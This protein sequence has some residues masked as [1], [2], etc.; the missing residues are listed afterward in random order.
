MSINERIG[1]YVHTFYLLIW[2]ITGSVSTD[3][4]IFWHCQI[5]PFQAMFWSLRVIF[6]S[7][8]DPVWTSLI[9]FDPIWSN[10]IKSNPIWPYV[11]LLNISA[12]NSFI[13]Q[14]ITV[15]FH[16]VILQII[17]SFHFLCTI[18]QRAPSHRYFFS[19][20]NNL[21]DTFE[22]MV[23]QCFSGNDRILY[24]L[25]WLGYILCYGYQV[26]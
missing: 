6:F 23:D 8:I 5:K 15:Q 7:S 9:Q 12:R 20:S 2:Y 22:K 1:L 3:I 17:S 11:L 25:L 13:F 19:W 26:P 24:P 21:F 4:Y 16:N 10:S 14:P 18:V